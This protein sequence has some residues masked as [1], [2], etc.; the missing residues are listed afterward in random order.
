MPCYGYRAT[1]EFDD[2]KKAQSVATELVALADGLSPCV[3]CQHEWNIGISSSTVT[4]E[5]FF[6]V[7]AN[8]DSFA[9]NASAWWAARNETVSTAT[10]VAIIEKDGPLDRAEVAVTI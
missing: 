4:C 8:R 1:F 6:E 5:V 7:E 9:T 3:D 2:K 10:A